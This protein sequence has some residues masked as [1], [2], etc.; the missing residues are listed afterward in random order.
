ML[1]LLQS[2]ILLVIQSKKNHQGYY[3][4]TILI[5]QMIQILSEK[6]TSLFC[7]TYFKY[8]RGGGRGGSLFDFR[9]LL[10]QNLCKN[11]LNPN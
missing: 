7:L 4:Y 3:D 11:Y 6:T 5:F 10:L 8:H 9:P 1:S 2:K